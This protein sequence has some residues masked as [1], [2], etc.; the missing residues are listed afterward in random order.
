MCI[1]RSGRKARRA[2]TSTTSRS[3]G[4]SYDVVVEG[5]NDF[6]LDPLQPKKPVNIQTVNVGGAKAALAKSRGTPVDARSAVRQDVN[7][8]APV[9][10]SFTRQQMEL[11]SEQAIA[12]GLGRNI[13]TERRSN[14]LGRTKIADESKLRIATRSSR[15]SLKTKKGNATRKA[16]RQA[17]LRINSVGTQ[18][19]ASASGVNIPR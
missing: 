3:L 7:V 4:G 19:G 15:S 9:K 1:S 14:P 13:T 8:Q 16:K 11:A 10:K 12:K 17:G 2:S 6:E 18:S 5:R